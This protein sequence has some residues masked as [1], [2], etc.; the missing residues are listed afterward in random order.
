LAEINLEC[1][2]EDNSAVRSTKNA[3][4]KC[5]RFFSS[6]IHLLKECLMKVTIKMVLAAFIAASFAVAALAADS[7]T[8]SSSSSQSTMTTGSTVA[9]TDSTKAKKKSKKVKKSKKTKTTT[10]T[11]TTP[12]PV[13]PQ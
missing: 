8:T 13:T 9:A 4:K 1:K 3:E 11:E 12:A 6:S 7:T 5:T 2:T 10:S